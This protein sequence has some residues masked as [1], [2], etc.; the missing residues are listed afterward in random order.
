MSAS[1]RR[2]VEVVVEGI[3]VPRWKA[4]AAAFCSRFMKEAGY[5]EWEI[6]VLLCGDERIAELNSR[7]RGRDAPTNVLSFPR[8]EGPVGSRVAGDIAVSVPM[9]RRNAVSFAVTED[10]ELKRLLAHGILH[11]A[12]M[13]HGRGKGPAMLALQES[14]L[15]RTRDIHIMA[16]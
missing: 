12:G 6:A 3:P 2:A 11:L 5:A 10:E 14:L 13:D 4:R 9:L 7:F 16:E 8:E 15:A 1:A